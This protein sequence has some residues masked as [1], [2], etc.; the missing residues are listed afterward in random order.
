M[1][2]FTSSACSVLCITADP[3][4]SVL[5]LIHR[6]TA[7]GCFNSGDLHSSCMHLINLQVI[8][9]TIFHRL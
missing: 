5:L 6:S 3:L 1:A 4:I 9:C 8:N 7:A 2:V